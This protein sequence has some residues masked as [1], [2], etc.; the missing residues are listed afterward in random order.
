M[1]RRA[2]PKAAEEST[3]LRGFDDFEVRL[4][5]IMR[6]ERATLGKSLLDVQRD[7]KIKATY[8]SA[9]ENSDPSA[10][11]TAGFIAGYVRS[12]ARYLGM[13]PDQVYVAFCQESGF[14]TPDGLSNR[15]SAG[16]GARS[17]AAN[18]PK[19]SDPLAD[20][21]PKFLPMAEPMF[22]GIE[23]AAIGSVLVMLGLI[24]GIGFGGWTVLQEIQR[25]DVAAVDE[26]PLEATTLDPLAVATGSIVQTAEA[27]TERSDA[28]NRLYRPQALE[29]PVLEPRDGPIASV[30]PRSVGLFVPAP[31]K[32]PVAIQSFAAAEETQEN[33]IQVVEDLAP[34][35]AIVAVRPSWVRVS[36]VDGSILLEKVLNAGES[37][38][39][40]ATE[41]PP[42]LRAGESGAIYFAVNGQ[43]YGP[44]GPFGV[45]TKNIALSAEALRDTYAL[46]D[47]TQDRDLAR[48]VA[49]AEIQAPASETD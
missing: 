43:H 8:I 34:T 46:A 45:V 38:E 1:I 19:Y 47:L 41:T 9:I 16:N 20:P 4:G 21:N 49:E 29:I 31:L 23:P 48:M 27:D 18:K 32:E 13:D 7:L 6:G 36:A 2:S 25:V 3:E 22:S 24:G 35:V 26:A 39:L 40:P 11:E 15:N 44:A 10:F 12:Y 30:D 33:V 5:D 14:Q 42:V 37:F 28:L 17:R